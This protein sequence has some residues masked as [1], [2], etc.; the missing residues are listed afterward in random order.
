MKAPQGP[1]APRLR[2]GQFLFW[3]RMNMKQKLK[4]L[5]MSDIPAEE[6]RWMW[7][8]YPAAGQ[9]HHHPGRSRRRQD[10][11]H[12]GVDGSADAGASHGRLTV[13]AGHSADGRG[14]GGA[15]SDPGVSG[16]RCG[17]APGQRGAAHLQTAGTAGGADRLRQR[18]GGTHKQNAVSQVRVSLAWLHRLP[19]GCVQCASG[20]TLQG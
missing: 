4:L 14:T 8:P 18:A 7:Q 16:E 19:G 9:D 15:R 10:H 11:L 2:T 6:V 12:A 1:A 5:I 17:H 3:R 20:G 13:G